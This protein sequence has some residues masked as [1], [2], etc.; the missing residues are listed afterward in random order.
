MCRYGCQQLSILKPVLE[1]HNVKLI[2]IGMEESLED[3]IEGH[4][5]SGDI[6]IDEKSSCY[7]DLRL[8]K[9]GLTSM[10]GLFDPRVTAA[11]KLAGQIPSNFN[12]MLTHGSQLGATFVVAAGGAIMMEHRQ[13]HHGDHVDNAQILDALKLKLPPGTKTMIDGPKE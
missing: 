6:F 9:T 11:Y 3:F 1:A 5:F 4:F 10:F 8:K 7:K 12:H 13:D 2:A